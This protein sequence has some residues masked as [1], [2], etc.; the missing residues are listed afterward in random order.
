MCVLLALKDIMRRGVDVTSLPKWKE[1]FQRPTVACEQDSAVA[2]TPRQSSASAT[3]PSLLYGS[4]LL[5]DSR[6]LQGF[7][8]NR[9]CNSVL[10]WVVVAT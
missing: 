5:L 6:M 7:I 4:L 2:V 1:K 3:I 10:S 9:D 8:C